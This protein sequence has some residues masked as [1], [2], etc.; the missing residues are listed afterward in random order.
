MPIDLEQML[1]DTADGDSRVYLVTDLATGPG[2]VLNVDTGEAEAAVCMAVEA[3]PLTATGDEQR[4]D[5]MMIPQNA[6]A[7]CGML[8]EELTPE[9]RR[10]LIGTWQQRG[11]L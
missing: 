9:L 11:F 2:S 8:F 1:V 6:Q 10:S 4:W 3:R 5:F 7:V